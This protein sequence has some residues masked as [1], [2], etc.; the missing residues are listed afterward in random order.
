MLAAL[1]AFLGA[2]KVILL[3]LAVAISEAL[4]LAGKGGV[5][6]IIASII[7]ALAGPKDPPALS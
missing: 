4:G 3:G 2:N 6:A 1:L 5:L 7:K